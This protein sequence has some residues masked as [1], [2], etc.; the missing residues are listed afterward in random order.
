[1][2]NLLHNGKKVMILSI[3]IFWWQFRIFD[4]NWN[5][6]GLQKNCH[7]EVKCLFDGFQRG[8]IAFFCR[9]LGDIPIVFLIFEVQWDKNDHLWRFCFFFQFSWNQKKNKRFY[10]KASGVYWDIFWIQLLKTL[11]QHICQACEQSLPKPNDIPG[12]SSAN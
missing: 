6:R 7:F 4:K 2:W 11:S 1:M 10:F 12:S 8:Q 9:L 5:F 3:A